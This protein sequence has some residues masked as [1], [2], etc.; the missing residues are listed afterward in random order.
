[1]KVEKI[2]VKRYSVAFKQE[3]VREYEAG[4]SES[5]LKQKYGIGGS[6]TISKWIKKY[7]RYGTRYE[8]MIIQKPEEQNQVKQL[9]KRV[10][11]LETALAQTVLDKLMLEALVAEIEAQTD[12]DL[13]KNIG[14]RSLSEPTTKP[15][16][17]RCQ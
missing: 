16:N 10:Q 13:K 2:K 17:R 4:R 12:V 11:E 1:V 6:T 9:Q 14:R 3:V 15:K 7:G 5:S 8:L